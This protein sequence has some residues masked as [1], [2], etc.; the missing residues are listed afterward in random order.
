M[1]SRRRIVADAAATKAAVYYLE[2]GRTIRHIWV[3]PKHHLFSY[4]QD[5]YEYGH[6]TGRVTYEPAAVAEPCRGTGRQQC[7][8]VVGDLWLWR[9]D[10]VEYACDHDLGLQLSITQACTYTCI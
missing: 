6:S 5:I 1:R 2:Q 4:L 10:R 3:S 8:R 7:G 9:H